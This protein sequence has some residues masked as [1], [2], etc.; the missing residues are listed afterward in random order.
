MTL[1]S[2][3]DG[4]VQMKNFKIFFRYAKEGRIFEISKGCVVE[5]I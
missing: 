4:R 5:H 1:L 2:I 3:A